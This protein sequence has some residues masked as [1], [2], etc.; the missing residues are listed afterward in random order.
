MS[1]IHS[2]N[3]T[4]FHG[5][6]A[7]WNLPSIGS[8]NNKTIRYSPVGVVTWS[9]PIMLKTNFLL[10]QAL[11]TEAITELKT[12]T[13]GTRNSQATYTTVKMGIANG[14]QAG[15]RVDNVSVEFRVTI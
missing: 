5:V 10:L 3:G 6:V 8:N 7:N 11:Q 13:Y 14:G 9:I 15:H 1:I 2:V 12:T 4:E